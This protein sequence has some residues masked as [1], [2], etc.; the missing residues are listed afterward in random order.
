MDRKKVTRGVTIVEP[1]PNVSC[2]R[3]SGHPGITITCRSC[4]SPT[5]WQITRVAVGREKE[6]DHIKFIKQYTDLVNSSSLDSQLVLIDRYDF[7]VLQNRLVLGSNRPQVDGHEQWGGKYSPYGHL[8][9]ALFVA[10]TE[11]TDN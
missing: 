11:V 3:M 6:N 5:Q 9:L 1:Q 4:S 10:Q 2:F 7:P 8:H